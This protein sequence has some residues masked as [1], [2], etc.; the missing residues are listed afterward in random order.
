[1]ADIARVT[2][3]DLRRGRQDVID[4]ALAHQLTTAIEV[5]LLTAVRGERRECA[6]ECTRRAELWERTMDNPDTNELLRT[7][8]RHR[9]NEAR[10]LADRI[11]TRE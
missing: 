6:A 4:P 2:V 3:D 1:M 7:E 11:A 9:A 8:A 10:S 5:A